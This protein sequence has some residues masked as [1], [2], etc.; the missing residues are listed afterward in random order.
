MAEQDESP[1]QRCQCAEC[2][3]ESVGVDEDGTPYCAS[4]Y[5]SRLAFWEKNPV[6]AGQVWKQNMTCANC[7]EVSTNLI[8]GQFIRDGRW[9]CTRKCR[10]ELCDEQP[11][12]D[13]AA[14]GGIVDAS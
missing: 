14:S 3:Q 4:H 9:V 7:G 12:D 11:Y 1:D 8:A 5:Q 2:D 10:D 6:I 13:L